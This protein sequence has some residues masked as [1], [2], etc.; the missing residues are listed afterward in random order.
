MTAAALALAGWLASGVVTVRSLDAPARIGLLSATPPTFFCV[1][2]AAARVG[3]AV[4]SRRQ[5]RM[6]RAA[7]LRG[8]CMLLA[9][10]VCRGCRC[11]CQ[12]HCSSGPAR[13]RS[14]GGSRLSRAYTLTHSSDVGRARPVRPRRSVSPVSGAACWP[15]WPS[16]AALLSAA[17][18]HTAPQHPKG[19][20]PDYLD[21]HAE[22]AARPRS[23]DRE[24]PHARRLRDVS[25]LAAL[26]PSYLA[27]G[28]DGAI[29]SVHAPVC[30]RCS[31]L[32]LRWADTEVPWRASIL[33][34]MAG[35]WLAWRT[36]LGRH[37]RRHGELGRRAGHRWL[38]AVLP[39]RRGDLSRCAGVGARAVRRRG[40]AT[41]TTPRRRR[42]AAALARAYMPRRHARSGRC[43]GCTP[44]TPCCLL[45]SVRRCACQIAARRDWR[46]AGS[47]PGASR[48]VRA[49]VVRVLLRHLRHAQSV[50]PYGAYTQMALAHLCRAVPGLLF[51]QQFGLLASAPVLAWRSLARATTA[52]ARRHR[53]LADRPARA[54]TRADVHLRG[55]RVS[56][57]VGRTVGAG[58]IPRAARFA[59]GAIDGNRLAVAADARLASPGRHA[60]RRV[61]GD[62]GGAGVRGSRRA[63][64][65]R[66][67]RTR[68]LGAVGEP[69][70]RSRPARCL[71]RTGTRLASC[72]AM[73]AS[74]WLPSA[75]TWVLGEGSN[76]ADA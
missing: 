46:G 15:R 10:V 70:R 26:P 72:C 67:R 54:W 4:A 38:G 33:C 11:P 50:C 52:R 75:S 55:R 35:A 73:P 66:A 69:A 5:R 74:G 27:R 18:W 25:P 28:T 8:L 14:A 48:G 45:A 20:E 47:V 71:R 19:D 13:W 21:H 68:P 17:A 3:S 43:R 32:A 58:A 31:C 22:P 2:A 42:G 37:A 56:H 51:D 65:Q 61:A 1:P 36:C 34:A 63:C 40:P 23:A 62:D 29:Y 49:R 12:P 41:G 39:A 44:V 9:P 6:E 60:A 24:Q 57:V 59:A 53:C 30:R 64:L 16:R 7:A 76:G